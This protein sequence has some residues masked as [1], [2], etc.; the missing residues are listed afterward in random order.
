MELRTGKYNV[1]ASPELADRVESIG[2]GI[3]RYLEK[4]EFSPEDDEWIRTTIEGIADAL[5]ESV[6]RGQMADREIEVPE[7]LY[8]N[9]WDENERNK[10]IEAYR[11]NYRDYNPWILY[12]AMF[13]RDCHRLVAR[14]AFMSTPSVLQ[15][16]RQIAAFAAVLSNLLGGTSFPL[17]SHHDHS[18]R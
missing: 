3:E 6:R 2:H 7:S 13:L 4:A 8:K 16:R 18:P 17:R 9:A 12:Q 15:A 5:R 1:K 14:S 10:I 11:L